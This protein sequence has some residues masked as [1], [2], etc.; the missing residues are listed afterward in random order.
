[1]AA[2][3]TNAPFGLMPIASLTG[4][5]DIPMNRYFIP[6]TDTNAYYIGSP[7]RALAN[8]DANGVPGVIVAAGTDTFLGSVVGV[9]IANVNATS[10]VGTTLALEQASIPAT[11]TRDYYVYVADDPNTI[12]TMQA[13]GTATN[14]TAAN[15]NK[16]ASMTIT[17]PSPASLPNSASVISSASIATN[18]TLNLRLMGL[19]QT[20]GSAFGAFSVYRCKINLHQ[21]ANG[22]TGV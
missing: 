2:P 17:A 1:M 11:K 16:N 8:A 12:F 10:M 6:S 14:Q 19:Y 5:D 3:N 13:D 21:Y 22:A 20:P 9:E 4:V 15:A 18:N 7:V